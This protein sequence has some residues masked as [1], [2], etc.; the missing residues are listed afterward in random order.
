MKLPFVPNRYLEH[1]YSLLREMTDSEIL[2]GIDG[3]FLSQSISRLRINGNR[4]RLSQ[5]LDE[6]YGTRGLPFVLIE[7]AGNSGQYTPLMQ[8]QSRSFDSET[9]GEFWNSYDSTNRM[10]FDW[11]GI[12]NACHRMNILR[13]MKRNKLK[14]EVYQ[15]AQVL[16]LS[17]NSLTYSDDALYSSCNATVDRFFRYAGK[18]LNK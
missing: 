17:A 8:S 12:T 15:L 1:P 18:L 10:A 9:N 6:Y 11:H 13:Q 5:V 7:N 14:R 2:A 3:L 16:R 4:L